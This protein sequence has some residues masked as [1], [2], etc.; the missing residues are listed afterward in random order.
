MDILGIELIEGKY[1]LDGWLQKVHGF[2]C[3]PEK[4]ERCSV[5]FDDRLEKLAKKPWS[6][7]INHLLPHC[8]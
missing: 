6:W 1:D 5:C 7:G 8:L 3:E 4:G 2:E